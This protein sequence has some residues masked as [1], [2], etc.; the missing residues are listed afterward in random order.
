MVLDSSTVSGN[1]AAGGGGGMRIIDTAVITVTNST[2]SGNMLSNAYGLGT[3]ISATPGGAGISG[4]SPKLNLLSTTITANTANSPNGVSTINNETNIPIRLKNTILAGNTGDVCTGELFS[5]GNNLFNNTGNCTLTPT[6]G[7]QIGINPKLGPLQPNGGAAQ[8]HALLAGSP[9]L[10]T[11]TC[12]G[13]PA[14]DQRGVAR[15]QGPGCGIGAHE[16]G[17][18]V[19]LA[20]STEPGSSAPAGVPFAV[21]PV[22]MAQD[23]YGNLANYNGPVSLTLTGAAGLIGTANATAVKGVANFSGLAVVQPGTGYTLVASAPGLLAAT[24]APV[25]VTG[26]PAASE[27]ELNNTIFQP[28]P[29]VFDEQAQTAIQGAISVVADV[30]LYS[31][32]TRPGA[33][34]TISLTNLPADYDLVLLPD[35]RVTLALSDSIDLGQI[36]DIREHI[37]DTREH[38]PDTG[39]QLPNIGFGVPS[40]SEITAR[41][42]HR[43]TVSEALDAYLPRGG[44]YFVLVYSLSSAFS[45]TLYRLDVALREGGLTQPATS[46]RPI[47]LLSV[48]RDSAVKTIF[49]Y[50]STRMITRYPAEADAV[51]D[52]GLALL[53]GTPLMMAS[54]GVAID[55]ANPP[56]QAADAALLPA[57]YNLWDAAPQQPLLANELAQQIF[58]ILDRAIKDAYPNTSDIVIVGGDLIIPFYRVPDEIEFA[59]EREYRDTL[60]AGIEP[61]SALNGTL[62]RGFIQT[63]NFYADRQP[64]PWRGRAMFL[65]DLG[66]GRLVERPSE[67]MRYLDDYIAS[68]N[69]TVDARGPGAAMVTGYDFLKDQAS[70]VA[71]QLGAYGLNVASTLN[72]DIWGLDAFTTCGLAVSCRGLARTTAACRPASR[73]PRSMAISAMLQ[74]CPPIHSTCHFWP[75]GSTRQRPRSTPI[76]SSRSTTSQP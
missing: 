56:V 69:Y 70:A 23:G 63:D 28:T 14:S 60:G 57:L 30:D 43:G 19:R 71:T 47:G 59:N 68:N 53:P 50:N 34:A 32:S 17:P 66:I 45:A 11:G 18:T 16:A 35:P 72:N 55:L 21:Q 22:V 33:T 26:A 12:T 75:S 25:N 9:A 73:S 15:P 10:D 65:P 49:V 5:Q 13:A 24:S 6:T 38:I 54:N 1:S 39:G 44:T 52:L 8:T 36:T 27:I 4:G 76:R 40:G 67:I 31:F 2:I 61:G 7:D 41:S 46:A 64:T 29:L 51:A 3:A 42:S 58:N 37:P 48:G 74:L 62:F 20:F